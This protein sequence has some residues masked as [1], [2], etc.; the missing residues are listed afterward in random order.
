LY[1]KQRIFERHRHRYEVNPKYIKDLEAKG[2]MFVALGAEKQGRKSIFLKH[3]PRME[4]ITLT[5]FFLINSNR[6][7]S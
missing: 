2:L 7:V 3:K 5:Y 1:K 6:F 4:V